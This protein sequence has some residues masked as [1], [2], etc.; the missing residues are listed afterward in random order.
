MSAKQ[1]AAIV[2]FAALVCHVASII[3]D[4]QRCKRNFDRFNAAPTG[5]NFVRLVLAEGALIGDLRWL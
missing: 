4:A 2:G 1:A 5:P 3:A